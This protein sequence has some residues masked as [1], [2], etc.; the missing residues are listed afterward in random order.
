MAAYVIP[1]FSSPHLRPPVCESANTLDP[2]QGPAWG[3]PVEVARQGRENCEHRD[4][5]DEG[6]HGGLIGEW[7]SV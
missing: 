2:V 7:V 4:I 5:S 1:L 6:E 3:L